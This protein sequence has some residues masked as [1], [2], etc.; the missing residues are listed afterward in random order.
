MLNCH[1]PSEY[2]LETKWMFEHLSDTKYPPEC[3]VSEVVILLSFSILMN[4]I[5]KTLPVITDN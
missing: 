1:I 2:A 4:S 3:T 5:S